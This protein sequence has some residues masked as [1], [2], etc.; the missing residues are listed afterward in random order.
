MKRFLAILLLVLILSGCSKQNNTIAVDTAPQTTPVTPPQPPYQA[1]LESMSNE[2]L[3]GQLFLARF[4]DANSAKADME[5]HHL[6]GYILFRSDIKEKTPLTLSATLTSLQ[7]SAPLPLLFAVDEEGGTVCRLSCYPQ[8]RAE[9]FPSPRTLYEAGGLQE[10]LDAEMEKCRLL[11]SLGINVNMAPVCDVTTDSR[12]FMYKRSLGQTPETTGEVISAMV[13]LMDSQGIGNVLKHFP[14]YGNN[15]DTHIGTATDNRSLAQ[16][17]SC[18]LV[19][20]RAGI[21]AGCDAILV[22]HTTVAC[23]DNNLPASLSPKVIDYLRNAMG[24][25]GVIVTD[26]LAMDAITDTF[27]V[28]ESAILAVLAGNDLICSSDYKVQYH[29]VLDAVNDGR[30]TRARLYESVRRIL[31]WKEN[32][33]LM[34]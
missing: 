3:V 29:A 7:E 28:G 12:A 33:G 8:Y 20:F 25:D 11:R 17:E 1:L 23:L 32:L 30:I 26:D 19:P 22:S 18:D 6:G 24:F 27:G 15:K 34:Q 14:G 2:A 16:L 9:R 31:L 5:K 21:E 10:V 13:D 4:P